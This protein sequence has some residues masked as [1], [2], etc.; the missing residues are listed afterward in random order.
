MPVML[1]VPAGE[2]SITYYYYWGNEILHNLKVHKTKE[3][4][5]YSEK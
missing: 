5:S 1:V 3:E 4:K 2:K